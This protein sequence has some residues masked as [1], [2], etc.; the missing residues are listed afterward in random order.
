MREVKSKGRSAFGTSVPKEE[1]SLREHL[2]KFIVTE[3]DVVHRVSA[4]LE[5]NVIAVNIGW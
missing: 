5:G 3:Q 4:V 2:L 1:C